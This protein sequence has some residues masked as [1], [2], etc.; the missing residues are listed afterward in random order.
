MESL[1]LSSIGLLGL[2]PS[3][4]LLFGIYLIWEQ[5]RLLNKQLSGIAQLLAAIHHEQQRTDGARG[6]LDAR[7]ERQRPNAT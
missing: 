6:P 7:H 4:L 2:L 1:V 3:I 5:S